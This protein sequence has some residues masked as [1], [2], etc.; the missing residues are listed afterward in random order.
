MTP[1]TDLNSENVAEF[2][3]KPHL[4]AAHSG[5]SRQQLINRFLNNFS[6]L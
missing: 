2:Q 3:E 6:T 1:G 5:I 4:A